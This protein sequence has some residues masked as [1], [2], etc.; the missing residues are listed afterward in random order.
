MIIRV[1]LDNPSRQN[2]LAADESFVV[3]AYLRAYNG[4]TVLSSKHTLLGR[5]RARSFARI[6]IARNKINNE[7]TSSP[8]R[9]F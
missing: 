5:F 6:L 7:N 8:C 1:I 3:T 2:F 9:N 4:Q